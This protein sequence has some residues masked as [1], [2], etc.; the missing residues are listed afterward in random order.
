MT[1]ENT[2]LDWDVSVYH[3][4]EASSTEL[5]LQPHG[6][7][8]KSMGAAWLGFVLFEI[9]V[10]PLITIL[11]A[12]VVMIIILAMLSATMPGLQNHWITGGVVFF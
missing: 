11:P 6:S 4:V 2:S 12:F 10:L 8:R 1:L 9:L 7:R 5:V 3:S